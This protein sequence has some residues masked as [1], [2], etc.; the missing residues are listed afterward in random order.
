MTSTRVADRGQVSSWSSPSRLT[1]TDEVSSSSDTSTGV[2]SANGSPDSEV[3]TSAWI[4][5]DGIPAAPS[6]SRTAS[7]NGCG[8]HMYA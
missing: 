6:P 5:P 1:C 8:P 3:N 7:M 4:R 2:I